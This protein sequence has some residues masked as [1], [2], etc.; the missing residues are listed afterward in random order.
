MKSQE[1]LIRSRGYWIANIQMDLFK[2]VDEYM[3]NNN[4]N[5]SQL[6]EKLGVTKGYIS[7]VLNGDFN[8]RVATFV[9]LAL[10]IG[11]VPKVEFEDLEEIISNVKDGYVVKKWKVIVNR[12]P[13]TNVTNTPDKTNINNEVIISTGWCQS[14]NNL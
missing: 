3:R 4:L 5:R 13:E 2:Y 9:D 14:V 12:N 11:K 6:A 1:E 7:Q 8:H 10:A